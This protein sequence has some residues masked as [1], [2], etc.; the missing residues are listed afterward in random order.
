MKAIPHPQGCSL[1]SGLVSQ[2]PKR[3]SQEQC[4]CVV[5]LGLFGFLCSFSPPLEQFKS[6]FFAEAVAYLPVLIPR[7]RQGLAAQ[8]WVSK[9]N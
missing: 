1:P 2:N 3:G 9:G 7:A 5:L 8:H 6:P 4:V